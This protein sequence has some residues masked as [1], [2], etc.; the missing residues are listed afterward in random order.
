MGK[1]QGVHDSADAIQSIDPALTRLVLA[2]ID[3]L[4][5]VA[6]LRRLVTIPSVNPPGD[7]RVAVHACAEPLA[8][9]GFDICT[10]GIDETKPD[11]RIRHRRRAYTLL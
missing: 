6:F 9:A 3:E 2:E 5:T 1:G 8:L 11:R 7:V 4:E 10:V